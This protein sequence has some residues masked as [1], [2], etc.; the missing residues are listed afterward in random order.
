MTW[1]GQEAGFYSLLERLSKIPIQPNTKEKPDNIRCPNGKHEW[2]YFG[3]GSRECVT[4]GHKWHPVQ[5]TEKSH[6]YVE[7][8]NGK[9][10]VHCGRE[11][12]KH[13]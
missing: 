7:I 13:S 3:H 8:K 5:C 11:F 6:H 10:C 12:G 9:H 2:R 1:I 4:C